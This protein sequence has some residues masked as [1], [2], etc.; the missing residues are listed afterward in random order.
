MRR[1]VPCSYHQILYL[2][3][4]DMVSHDGKRF[5]TMRC[6]NFERVTQQQLLGGGITAYRSRNPLSASRGACLWRNHEGFP[7][8]T[9]LSLTPGP[10]IGKGNSARLYEKNSVYIRLSPTKVPSRDVA[11]T[12]NLANLTT[13]QRHSIR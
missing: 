11:G 2:S 7:I 10:R 13:W 3:I 5:L 9:T 6:A 8:P 4:W 12:I 1:G